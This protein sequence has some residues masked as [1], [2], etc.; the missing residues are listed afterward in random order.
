MLAFNSVKLLPRVTHH[1][2][3]DEKCPAWVGTSC[4]RSMKA[5]SFSSPSM[6]AGF[7]LMQQLVLLKTSTSVLQHPP[8]SF[9]S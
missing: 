8:C 4:A 6:S 5:V 9:R 1:L 3:L 2:C 7:L